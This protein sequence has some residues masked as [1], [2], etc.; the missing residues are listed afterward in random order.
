MNLL[1]FTEDLTNAY[2]INVTA[3]VTPNYGTAPDGTQTSTR[4]QFAGA[5]LAI[6]KGN[7][8]STPAPA[9]ASCYVKGVAGETLMVENNLATV[10]LITLTGAWQ[11]A[12]KADGTGTSFVIGTY[13]GATAR[14]IEVWH[15][16]F[17]LGLDVTAYQSVPGD[18]STYDA[19][20]I[21]PFQLYDGVD[22]GMATASFAAGT[23]INGMDCMI[24][25]RRDSAA[26]AIFGLY[27]TP[28]AGKWFG[29]A[30][31]TYGGACFDACGAPTTWVDGVQ[32]AGG[33][34]T[35]RATLNTALTPGGFHILEFRGLD[36]SAWTMLNYGGFGTGFR[37]N[38][39][40]GQI[41]LFASGQDANRDKAR[42]QM[43]AYFGV[44]L[45]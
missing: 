16:Q 40:L 1:S 2:W 11:L 5:N 29:A 8:L 4:L 17:Q 22:D 15:P 31:S 44:T 42:A 24:A 7:I 10:N 14:D 25:V 30:D 43:A 12:S 20:G 34:A 41:E 33:T 13:G 38:G 18:G 36:L 35:T 28:G 27:N 45:P 23:L 3:T 6:L 37:L 32:L 19:T 21:T 9:A 26:D 39:A